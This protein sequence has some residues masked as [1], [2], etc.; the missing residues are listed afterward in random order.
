LWKRLAMKSNCFAVAEGASEEMV[1]AAMGAARMMGGRAL[2]RDLREGK[3]VMVNGRR[4][5]LGCGY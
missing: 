3:G 2:K 4:G 1:G 5:F